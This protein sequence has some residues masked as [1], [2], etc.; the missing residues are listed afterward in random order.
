MTGT[1]QTVTPRLRS[2][3]PWRAIVAAAVVAAAVV[4]MA[5]ALR[6]H[7]AELK[8][9][10]T[11][12][13]VLAALG[14]A[15]LVMLASAVLAMVAWRGILA[16]LGSRLP[17][18]TS[19]RI[20]FVTLLGAYLPGPFW[21]AITGVHLGRRAGVP[22]T[23][24]ATGY[25]LSIVVYLLCAAPVAAILLPFTPNIDV[26]SIVAPIG[27]AGILY[28]RPRLIIDLGVYLARLLRR[29]PPAVEGK[30]EKELRRS[31]LIQ[32]VS[33]L[34]SGVHLWIIAIALGAAPGRSLPITIGAFAFATAAGAL[35]IFTPDGAGVRELLLTGVLSLVLPLP[36]AITA[37]LASRVCCVI[38]D[39]LGAA[40]GLA[41]TQ[42]SWRRQ[43]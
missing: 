32:T 26:W 42:R 27:I 18:L 24:M 23:R 43:P 2:R 14:L 31:M 39:A 9:L 30:P 19:T 10:L 41:L 17:W 1:A 11:S 15:V 3:V 22:A 16:A 20:Y 21:P 5:G 29:D 37:A 40:G 4:G 34:V 33:W 25:L 7:G 6:G 28:W 12:P 38:A 13:G 35:V 8:R 36:Q